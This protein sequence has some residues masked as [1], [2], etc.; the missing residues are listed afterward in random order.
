MTRSWDAFDTLLGRRWITPESIWEEIGRQI[1]DDTFPQRRVAA[2]K[3]GD[4]T[5]EDTYKRLGMSPQIEYDL[6]LDHTYGILEN[7]SRLSNADIIVSDMYIPPEFLRQL[8]RHNGCDFT[9]NI[10]ISLSGKR[11]GTIWRGLKPFPVDHTGDNYL[12]DVES[13]AKYGIRGIHYTRQLLTDYENR[14]PDYRL[15]AFLRFLRMQCPYTD[16]R[17][18]VWDDQCNLNVPFLIL[19]SLELPKQKIHFVYRDCVFL[20]GIFEKLT[21]IECDWLQSSRAV[22]R[23]GRNRRYDNYFDSM[24]IKLIVDLQ[25]TGRSFDLYSRL[26]GGLDGI[27]CL[28]LTGPDEGTLMGQSV[29]NGMRVEYYNL[30]GEGSLIGWGPGP[31]RADLEHDPELVSVMAEVHEV[32]LKNINVYA[33]FEPNMELLRHTLHNICSINTETVKRVSVTHKKIH[34]NGTYL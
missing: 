30:A 33:P 9:G 13:P 24:D 21:G 8:L 22:Y 6:E 10:F 25:G 26:R 19:S 5:L 27:S 31:I 17:Q 23:F 28:M 29:P 34:V 4:R 2:Y 14:V 20:K 7:L 16:W 15:R 3:A 32:V 1:G 12:S 11:Q 18:K